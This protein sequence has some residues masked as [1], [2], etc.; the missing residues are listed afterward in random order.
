MAL[1]NLPRTG[2]GANFS[3]GFRDKRGWLSALILDTNTTKRVC[4]PVTR[5]LFK[6]N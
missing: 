5:I 4:H 1:H 3:K 6:R 2:T